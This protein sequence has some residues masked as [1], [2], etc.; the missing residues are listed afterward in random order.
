MPPIRNGAVADAVPSALRVDRTHFDWQL[1]GATRSGAAGGESL[2]R[3]KSKAK[4]RHQSFRSLWRNAG[5]I[6]ERGCT[7][8][9]LIAALEICSG[10]L[11]QSRRPQ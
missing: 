7:P 4:T 6:Q 11:I 2:S 5:E 1:A 9:S 10:S 3:S 8:S